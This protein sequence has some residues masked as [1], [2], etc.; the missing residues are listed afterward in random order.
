MLRYSSVPTCY[1]L[2]CIQYI[3]NTIFS[4]LQNDAAPEPSTTAVRDIDPQLSPPETED[5]VPVAV[6][7]EPRRS[8]RA[9]KQRE[10]YDPSTGRS[11]KATAV[12]DT[13]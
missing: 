10:F 9:R 4:I 5:P 1:S 2:L 3:V 13:F 6:R 8:A 11:V 12:P 7:V